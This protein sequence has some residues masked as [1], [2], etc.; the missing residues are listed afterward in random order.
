MNDIECPLSELPP[1]QCACPNHRGG[2]APGEEEVETTGQPFD[3]QYVAICARS[4]DLIALGDSIA[5][6][7]EGTGY[8]HVP[9]CP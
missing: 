2:T 3:A 5:R 6:V 1:S 4:H 8:A 9:R 7:A